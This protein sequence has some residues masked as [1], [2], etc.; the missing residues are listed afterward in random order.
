MVAFRAGDRG[1]RRAGSLFHARDALEKR[2]AGQLD[3]LDENPG[4]EIWRPDEPSFDP[5]HAAPA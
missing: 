5:V 1:D 3:E 4:V 2:A